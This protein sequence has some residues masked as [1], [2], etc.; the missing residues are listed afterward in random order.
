MIYITGDIHGECCRVS[1]MVRYHHI[2]PEDTIVLLGDVAMNYYGAELGDRSR[3]ANLVQ[4]S[5]TKPLFISRY[6]QFYV[7]FLILAHFL[8]IINGLTIFIRFFLEFAFKIC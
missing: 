3:K 4:F 8:I 7:L 1:D 2:T 6:A 5:Y